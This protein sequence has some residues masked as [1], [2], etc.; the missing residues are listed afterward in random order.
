MSIEA[1]EGERPVEREDKVDDVREDKLSDNDIA[2][3]LYRST[4]PRLSVL[5]ISNCGSP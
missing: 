5:I 1:I 4:S 3:G 2:E